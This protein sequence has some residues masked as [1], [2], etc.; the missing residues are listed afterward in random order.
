MASCQKVSE[1]LL[2]D[3]VWTLVVVMEFVSERSTESVC[4][5]EMFE[6]CP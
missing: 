4:D 2:E 6:S 5:L 1:L 3:S